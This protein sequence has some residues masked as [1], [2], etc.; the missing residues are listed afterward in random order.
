ML[1]K[2]GYIAP[3]VKAVRMLGSWRGAKW[4]L[5]SC[6]RGAGGGGGS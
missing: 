5:E 6:G 2:R 3:G 4:V 1:R